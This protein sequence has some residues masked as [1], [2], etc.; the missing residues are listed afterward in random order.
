MELSF[1]CQ[2]G[3]MG[4]LTCQGGELETIWHKES[5]RKKESAKI[6]RKA[7]RHKRGNNWS[8][9]GVVS[10]LKFNHKSMK[11]KKSCHKEK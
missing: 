11:A 8:K 7:T 3:T 6:Q 10:L 5:N 1:P 9:E 2:D 4:N